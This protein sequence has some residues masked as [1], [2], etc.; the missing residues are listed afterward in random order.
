MIHCCVGITAYNEEANIGRLLAALLAQ[1]TSTVSIDEIIVVASGCT[2][3]TEEIVKEFAARDRRILLLSQPE[4][5]GKASAVNL[6]LRNTLSDVIVLE[7]AD[8]LPLPDTLESLVSSL[9]DP[10]IGMVGGRPVPTNSTDHFMGFGVHL[11][12][13]LHHQVSMHHPK[14]GELIAFRNIFHQIP[15]ETA[16][17]EA[18]IEPLII[19]QGLRLHYAPRAIVHNKGPENLS[20]FFKQRRR[21][22]PGHLYV[23]DTLGY[24][25]STLNG[26]RIL[27]LFLQNSPA[28]IKSFGWRYFV[29]GMAI[30]LLEMFVRLLATY[31]YVVWKRKPYAWPVA[32]STKDLAEVS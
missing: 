4:R 10:K 16:V 24:K 30:G 6:L 7:S 22:F 14:M 5:E 1:E 8:T 2:D 12:W 13:D 3:R 18:S 29:W 17:D 21:I 28:A 11:L 20:D 19:G 27:W 31:D 26:L 15:F 23:K 9:S 25:V 32:E